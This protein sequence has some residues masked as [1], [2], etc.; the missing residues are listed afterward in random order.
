M[1]FYKNID[2]L[3][4][5]IMKYKNG[6]ES[7]KIAENGKKKYTKYFNSNLVADFILTKTLGKNSKNKFI[8]NK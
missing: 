6:S 8:W 7:K 4:E 3:S 2:D 1:V 5:K